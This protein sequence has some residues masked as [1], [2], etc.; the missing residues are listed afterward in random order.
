MRRHLTCDSIFVLNF[1]PIYVPKVPDCQNVSK[2]TRKENFYDKRFLM[3]GT[4]LLTPWSRVL[5]EKLTSSAA[6]QE[7]P[8]ILWNPKVHYRTYKCPPPV[9]ILTQ[10]HPV[11]TTPSNFLKIHLNIMLPSTSGSCRQQVRYRIVT[12]YAEMKIMQCDML[13]LLVHIKSYTIW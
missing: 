12:K 1:Q 13:R 4:Y 7:I 10:L 11:P 8:R 9:P 2:I 5:L 3:L 6:S